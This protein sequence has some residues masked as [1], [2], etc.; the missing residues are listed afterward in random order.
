MK[1]KTAHLWSILWIVLVFGIQVS[2]AQNTPA[3]VGQTEPVLSGSALKSE[4]TATK[5][6]A[7]F[8]GEIT[9]IGGGNPKAT[10]RSAY[11]GVQ[12]KVLQVLRGSVAP[13]VSVTLY[14]RFEG[15]VHE[16][17]PVVGGTYIFFAHKNIEP[18]VDNYTVLKLLP[19]TDDSTAAVKKLI[20]APAGK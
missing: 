9:T 18:G 5:V 8:V 11:R 13:Q 4:D 14:A 10:G 15:G 17:P 20:P 3:G 1:T 7:V 12:V 19:A 16:Q 6:D 2:K